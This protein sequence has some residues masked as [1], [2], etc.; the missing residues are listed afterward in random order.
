[1]DRIERE[2][3][4][5]EMKDRVQHIYCLQ[6]LLSSTKIAMEDLWARNDLE[7]D[8]IGES[9]LAF[10]N[11]LTSIENDLENIDEM[12]SDIIEELNYYK[13]HGILSEELEG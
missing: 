3:R 12:A 8:E 11:L 1:M 7:D 6:E 5:T 13:E 9:N 2:K 10:Q 4:V